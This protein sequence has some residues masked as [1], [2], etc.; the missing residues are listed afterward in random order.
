[1]K[2]HISLIAAAMGVGMAS[3]AYADNGRDLIEANKCSRCHRAQTT[4]RGPS[5]AS[6]AAKYQGDAAAEAR[7]IDVLKT[8]GPKDHGKVG[9]SETDLKAMVQSV[10]SSK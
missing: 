3:S 10:L 7:L 1:M 5:F 2:L 6:L 8:G 9:A 4:A